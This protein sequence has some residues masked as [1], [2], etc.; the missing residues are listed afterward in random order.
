MTREKQ[1]ITEIHE[2]TK[3]TLQQKTE[4]LTVLDKEL[5]ECK[6]Q[7]KEKSRKLQEVSVKDRSVGL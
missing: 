7:L 5:M 1:R 2:E 4:R 6:Q 3:R